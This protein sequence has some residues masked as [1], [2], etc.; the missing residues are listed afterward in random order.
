MF[1]YIVQI[2][3]LPQYRKLNRTEI[4]TLKHI[5][6]CKN[7]MEL[8]RRSEKIVEAIERCELF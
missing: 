7:F 2:N 6:N 5:M 4:L 8:K 3:K 1:V